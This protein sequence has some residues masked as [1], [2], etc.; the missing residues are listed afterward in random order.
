MSSKKP[1]SPTLRDRN[2]TAISRIVKSEFETVYIHVDTSGLAGNNV[3][4][5]AYFNILTTTKWAET[6]I[7]T[8]GTTELKFE[9]GYGSYGVHLGTATIFYTT[10]DGKS[11][12]LH[13]PIVE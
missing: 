4:V 11:D 12:E 3:E 5:T 1:V 9:V 10:L 8:P 7:W 2:G 6:K 13:V